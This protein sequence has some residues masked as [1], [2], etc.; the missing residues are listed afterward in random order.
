MGTPPNE[1]WAEVN[2]TDAARHDVHTGDAVEVAGPRSAITATVRVG[3]IRP[4]VLFVPFHYG[5][6]VTPE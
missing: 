4:G 1:R 2:A 3:G 6:R 5:T